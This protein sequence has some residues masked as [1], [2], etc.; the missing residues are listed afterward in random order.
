MDD[1]DGGLPGLADQLNHLFSTIPKPDG[2]GFWSNISAAAAMAESGVVVTN[3]YLSQLRRGK[4]NNPTARVLKAIANLF[5][6]P[7]DYFL[8]EEVRVKVD[9]DISLLFAL[10]QSGLRNAARAIGLS[11]EGLSLLADIAEQMRRYDN[12]RHRDERAT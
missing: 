7:I 5:E 10:R 1:A 6:V 2:T 4:R 11:P 9:N 8:E 12:L 3:G